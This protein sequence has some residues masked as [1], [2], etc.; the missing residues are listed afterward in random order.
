ML[1]FPNTRQ[2]NSVELPIAIGAFVT[3][4]GCALVADN[5][6]G[7]FG[8]KP[9]TGAAG[10]SF[11]GVSVSQQLPLLNYPKVE[12]KV[13]G[14]SNVITLARIPSAGTS[15]VFNVTTG[16]P[17]V[18]TTDYTIS[19]KVVTLQAATLGATIRVTYKFVPDA[20][21]ARAIQGDIYPGGATGTSLSQVGVLRSGPVYTTEYDGSVNWAVAAP[22]IKLGAN[23]LFTI[24][25]S[26]I[27]VDAAVLQVPTSAN[28]FLG[29]L[30]K[31][32]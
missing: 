26:G 27:T 3:A 32:A 20:T 17:L 5:T 8:A 25:G 7:I 29:L 10:E 22:V 4:E 9:S 24:G 2:A 14:A 23:G 12:E 19:G 11:L 18:V 28:P 30:L 21:E 6:N 15:L 13:Q 31:Q 16:L 1:Y